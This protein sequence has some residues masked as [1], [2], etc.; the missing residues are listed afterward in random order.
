MTDPRIANLIRF[1]DPNPN[2][3]VRV[4][5]AWPGSQGAP[6][7]QTTRDVVRATE[8]LLRNAYDIRGNRN[9]GPVET[10]S[11]LREASA[12]TLKALNTATAKIRAAKD[13]LRS[14]AQMLNPAKPYERCGYWQAQF[15]LRIIDNYHAMP[16]GQRAGIEHQMREI[17]A[18]HLNLAEA[19]LRV[20]REIAKIDE[21]LRAEI[22]LGL[23]KV[24]KHDEF[25]AIDIQ[26]QQLNVAESVLRIAVET[27][28]ETTGNFTDLIEHA[29]DAYRF[30]T[31]EPEGE[32][33][34][35]PPQPKPE[36]R[37]TAA[38]ATPTSAPPA[39]AETG[40]GDAS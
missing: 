13:E 37:W 2:G 3:R 1:T 6:L 21:R 10:G 26:M 11:R 34:W 30:T 24:L 31:Q 8:G 17:P 29:P 32:L 22:R 28:R 14:Q 35:L 20:P 36:H 27:A 5:P 23:L 19:L 4:A 12:P 15:D 25:E 38:D 16:L 7:A 33:S 39:V 18:M 40:A 9:F